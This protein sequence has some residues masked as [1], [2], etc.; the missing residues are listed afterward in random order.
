MPSRQPRWPS[1]GLTSCSLCGARLDLGDVDAEVLGHLL[2]ARHRSCGRN[3]CSGGSSRRMVTGRPSMISKSSTKSSRCIGRIL[4][5]ALRA[6][7]RRRRPGSSRARRRCGRPRRTCARCGRG[8]CPRRRTRA[9]CAASCGV[10]ALV[11]TFSVRTSSA[12]SISVAKSPVSSG[13]DGRHVAQH[14]LAGAA[15]E[16]DD[17]AVLDAPCRSTR[18][19]LGL[20]R[21]C[22]RRRRRRRRTCPCRGRRRPRGWSCRRAR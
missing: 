10:S 9:P 15:V 11:R 17:L 14:D 18:D 2:H 8:R 7:L 16:R 22:A 19:R 12:H 6:A 21:R 4:A 3:S 20:R 13:C 1:I 5:S